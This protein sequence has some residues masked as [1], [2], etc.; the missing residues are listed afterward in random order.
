MLVSV[1]TGG[2]LAIAPPDASRRGFCC[3]GSRVRARNPTRVTGGHQELHLDGYRCACCPCALHSRPVVDARAARA[4]STPACFGSAAACCAACGRSR[5]L[6]SVRLAARSFAHRCSR[7][8]TDRACVRA[9]VCL[10]KA[11]SDFQGA[12]TVCLL[13][14]IRARAT[15]RRCRRAGCSRQQWC[16]P[17]PMLEHTSCPSLVRSCNP[18]MTGPPRHADSSSR[19]RRTAGGS[20]CGAAFTIRSNSHQTTHVTV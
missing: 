11:E 10:G 15:R 5:T 1:P 9:Q 6:A 12:S 8:C 19:R 17:S 2:R 3:W 18:S 7:R 13:S 16:S 14:Y 4:R 20:T